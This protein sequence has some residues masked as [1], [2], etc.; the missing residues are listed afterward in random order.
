MFVSLNNIIIILNHLTANASY[1]ISNLVLVLKKTY[2]LS[3][4]HCGH[5]R[6]VQKT[7]IFC[8]CNEIIVGNEVLICVS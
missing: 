3:V 5:V 4:A 2:N 1:H 7:V 6:M 8:H